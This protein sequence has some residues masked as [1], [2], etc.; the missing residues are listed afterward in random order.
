MY[1]LCHLITA[2]S[3]KRETPPP[4]YWGE[5]PKFWPV[6]PPLPKVTGKAEPA[7]AAR[8]AALKLLSKLGHMDT[9]PRQP[10]SFSGNQNQTLPSVPWTAQM[11]GKRAP[12]AHPPGGPRTG[13]PRSGCGSAPLGGSG[14]ENQGGAPRKPSRRARGPSLPLPGWLP[15]QT[16]TL[17]SSSEYKESRALLKSGVS[18]GTL[19]KQETTSS[20]F[21]GCGQRGRAQGPL[22]HKIMGQTRTPPPSQPPGCERIQVCAELLWFLTR[23]EVLVMGS[24]PKTRMSLCGLR[25]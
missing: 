8:P 23:S 22:P 11:F 19:A 3:R 16:L 17:V 14:T 15:A 25:W 13:G 4:C 6:Q 20:K 18:L 21:L 12:A 24:S 2:T 5:K 1:T 7:W 10:S 9:S